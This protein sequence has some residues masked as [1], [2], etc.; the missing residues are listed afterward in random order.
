MRTVD[1]PWSPVGGVLPSYN[2]QDAIASLDD[3]NYHLPC[4]RFPCAI[5]AGLAG[6]WQD[7]MTARF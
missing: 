6:I 4:V 2:A 1:G 3:P 7:L 5:L